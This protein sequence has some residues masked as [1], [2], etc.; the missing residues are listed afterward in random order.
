MKETVYMEATI[1]NRPLF[2]YV[3]VSCNLLYR[4]DEG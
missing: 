4:P 3:T 2:F 1:D